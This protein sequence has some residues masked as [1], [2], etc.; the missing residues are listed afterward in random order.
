MSKP[1]QPT[2][3]LCGDSAIH[4]IR[5]HRYRYGRLNWRSLGA[6]EQ[7]RALAASIPNLRN[8]DWVD[9][10]ANG[11]WHEPEDD[12][13]PFLHVLVGCANN[14]RTCGYIDCTTFTKKL[15]P[16]S[17]LEI[18]PGLYSVSPQLALVQYAKNHTPG[19]VRGLAEELTGRFA[20]PYGSGA[21]SDLD[22]LG[23]AQCDPAIS[24][25]ELQKWLKRTK[26]I[27]GIQT[28]RTATKYVL[29]NARSPM[30]AIMYGI[31]CSPMHAGGF[32]C[33]N[34]EPN[35][36]IE[37]SHA[38]IEASQMPYAVAD[39]Y[40]RKA[41]I[42]LEYNGEYHSM[43][44]SRRHDERRTAGLK[45][46]G[47]DVVPLND[48]QLCNLGA[49][50]SIARTIYKAE[51]RRFRYQIIGYRSLQETYLSELRAWAG[52]GPV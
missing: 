31:F 33:A 32:A 24:V 41:K 40:F 20:L 52:L 10:S 9:L 1:A 17:L 18:S 29:G 37:F 3:V 16:N 8:I 45:A 50:E 25:V 11:A 26:G 30:E 36:R 34:G 44:S 46:M 14:V 43:E 6:V 5:C 35:A 22:A 38:A 4:A 13:D 15:P 7:R 21:L 51:G 19:E 47:I 49:L 42:A 39:L 12:D 48:Q 28:A 2:I 27:D 23:Y